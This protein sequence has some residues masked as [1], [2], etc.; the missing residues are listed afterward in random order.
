MSIL[1]WLICL[2]LLGAI[3][4][5]ILRKYLPTI[6]TG[7]FV[8][9]IPLSIFIYLLT[10]LPIIGQSQTII[11]PL[12]M[13][14]HFGMSF[15]LYLDGLSLLFALLISGIGSCVIFYSVFYLNKKK[16]DL[17]AFYTYLLL[18]MFAMLG[19]VL[20]NNLLSI[21][22]FW[23]FTSLASFLLIGFWHYRERSRYGALKSM[24][25]TVFGGLMMLG[26]IAII[27]NLTQTLE[28]RTLITLAPQFISHP[29][30]TLAMIGILLGAFTK[31]AQFPFS[32]WLPD[33]MEAPTPVSAYLHSATMVKAG[34][35]LL[36]RLTPIFA[37]NTYWSYILVIGGLT[38]LVLGSFLSLREHDLK[39]LLAYSTISQ[40]GLMTSMLGVGG[41]SFSLTTIN[42]NIYA[43]AIFGVIF[44]II[45][46]ALFKGT[47]FMITGIIDH[48]TG[49]RDIRELSGLMHHM[50]IVFTLT[51]IASL[52]MAG[53]PPFSG[54]LSKEFFLDSF[55]IFS[56]S[57]VHWLMKIALVVAIFASIF[58]F[59]YSA[60]IMTKPF[61]GKF[62]EEKYPRH[63]HKETILMLASPVILVLL[64]LIISL[65]PNMLNHYIIQPA[66]QAILLPLYNSD[67][68]YEVHISY[69]HGF[70]PTLLCTLIIIFLGLIGFISFKYWS[71]IY[72]FFPKK[73]SVNYI[74]NT[75]IY[76][77]PKKLLTLLKFIMNGQLRRYFIII[78]SFIIITTSISLTIYYPF[79]IDI[80]NA[81]PIQW[82]NIVI[83]I[84]IICCAVGIC[85][86][87]NR[88]LAI[89]L[90]SGIGFSVTLLYMSFKA[91]DL[92]FTQ[93]TIESIST[94]LFLI[95]FVLLSKNIKHLEKIKFKMTN[96]LIA[97]AVGTLFTIIGLLAYSQ[98]YP[99]QLID[100]YIKNV[101]DL[102]GGGNIV[103][104]IIVDF[105]GYDTMFEIAVLTIT[106]L[107]IYGLMKTRRLKK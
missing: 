8:F 16:E 18:F 74:Y 80:T 106:G 91:P 4:T 77:L 7:L 94:I 95:A 64:I 42:E 79:N 22:M 67:D 66:T 89:L 40:L 101:H 38:T 88:L 25:I 45:N 57:H 3:L 73:I 55:V 82:I 37:L 84:T 29:A 53:L 41:L 1:H 100:Y 68:N 14:N 60:I 71:Y 75:L 104:V 58:T 90:S 97:V 26:A 27:Y 103:N 20:S 9:F 39:G 107:A 98:K 52:S 5:P 102:A 59:I 24:M 61:L 17:G 70:T 13:L 62:I 31:S 78:L 93:F 56:Q 65:F 32:I 63:I 30:F 15:D 76:I 33:A 49:T 92:A 12:T 34:I 6:H 36:A 96:A 50:P 87:R 2:P 23:E 10:L 54:F 81:S 43:V 35:Y 28:I 46:H 83:F 19:V 48:E 69:W 47:L 44:H 21:Y 86:T 99:A 11:L 72:K 85:F 51:I 105:R